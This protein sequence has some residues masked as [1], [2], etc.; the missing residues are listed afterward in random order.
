MHT[1][2]LLAVLPLELVAEVEGVNTA[3]VAHPLDSFQLV[4]VAQFIAKSEVL[5]YDPR[6]L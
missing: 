5:G 3:G 2:A 4:V 6:G 1:Y